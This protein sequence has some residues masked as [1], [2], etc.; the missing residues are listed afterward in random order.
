MKY[1]THEEISVINIRRISLVL[2]WL[3]LLS[4]F[5][6]H[7]GD[8]PLNWRADQI[9]IYAARAPWD[10]WITLSMILVSLA[11][12]L[13]GILIGR[14]HFLGKHGLSQLLPQ[15]SGGIIA[16]LFLIAN[17]E[18]VAGSFAELRGSSMGTIHHQGFHDAGLY[19][20]FHGSII[21]VMMLGLAM[22]LVQQN[23]GKKLLGFLIFLMGPLAY[24]LMTGDW[25]QWLDLSGP[26]I[27]IKQRASLFSLW[28]AMVL[29]L[30]FNTPAR[31]KR[32][33]DSL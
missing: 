5:L 32:Y 13:L 16:G 20:L 1:H 19:L 2:M 30:M 23:S 22:M 21:L 3:A 11:M 33:G 10:A 26:T 29:L 7:L 25:P 14:Y 24:M 15:L 4:M 6:G 8:H 28:L 18:A 27:G 9:S 12:V 31:Q 17:F